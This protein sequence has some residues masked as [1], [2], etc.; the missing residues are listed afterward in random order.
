MKIGY[1]RVSK[2]D[3]SQSLD[4][5][6]DALR[7]DGVDK[8][9][10]Y[11]DMASGRKDHRPGLESCLKALQPGNT[12]VIWKLDRLGRD[13]KHLV[14]LVDELNSKNI[15]LKVLTGAGAQIDTSTANGKLVFGIFA[16]LAEFERELIA[17]RTRAG[18]AA[19]RARGRK[20]GRPRKMD[21]ATLM[22]AV[23]A[24]E[25]KSITVQ[26]V[27]KRLNMTTTTLY[28]YLNGDGSMKEPGYKLLS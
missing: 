5:Q 28:M 4:L 25:D 18:L 20:G 23:K 24:L 1:M 15:G 8:N 27:A 11:R 21:K 22:M 10:I 14:T 12:L 2:T 7:A 9:R 26:E 3:G 6:S 19:A 13:L 17:E 16:A